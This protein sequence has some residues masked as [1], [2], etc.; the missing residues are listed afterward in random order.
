ML[1]FKNL[2][3][4]WNKTTLTQ[5][6]FYVSAVLLLIHV[7]ARFNTND[8]KEGF[9]DKTKDFITKRG[10]NV[11]DDFYVSIYDDLLHSEIKNTY[12]IDNIMKMTNPTSKSVILDVGS[13]TGH[14][15]NAFTRKNL[16]AIGLDL[17]PSMVKKSKELY[18][19]C[20]FRVGNVLKTMHFQPDTLTHIT[21]LYF[22]IY[23]I[24]NKAQFFTNC[25]QWLMPGGHL[26]LHLVDRDNFDPIIPAGDPFMVVSP[27]KYADKRITSTIVKFDEFEY[28][29]NFDVV[30]DNDVA[31]LNELFKYKNKNQ[32]RKNEHKL[33]MAPQRDI[34]SMAKDA[35]FILKDKIDMTPCQYAD[36]Y[37]YILQK[38]Q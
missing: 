2:I 15:V 7:I 19:D 25:I 36:Q 31:I 3:K 21:C 24:E 38:P 16:K 12:E 5:K 22:T 28:K 6:V 30:N 4:V 14:H 32:I 34:L 33:F 18:P 17:S 29:A 1:V 37:L 10:V 8:I 9:N 26:V 27:Q 23:Y 20:D 11:Y 13:G 35:G